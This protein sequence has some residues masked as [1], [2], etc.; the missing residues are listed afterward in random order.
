MN[1]SPVESIAQAGGFAI[2]AGCRPVRARNL[3]VLM[4]VVLCPA[5]AETQIP[6]INFTA[7]SVIYKDT[8]LND[9]A[10]HYAAGGSIRFEASEIVLP[11]SD[12]AISGI[13]LDG[14]LHELSPGDRSLLLQ[15]SVRA[16]VYSAELE[17]SG[18]ATD[19]EVS[20]AIED[21]PLVSLSDIHGIPEQAG[22]LSGGALNAGLLYK[23]RQGHEPAITYRLQVEDLAFDSPQGRFAGEG[24]SLRA[25][26]SI[27]IKKSLKLDVSGTV[28]QGE[29]LIDNFYR[30][31]SDAA[32]DFA[33][34][35]GWLDDSLQL[36]TILLTDNSALVFEGRAEIPGGDNADAWVLEV[37]RL[38]LEFPAAYERYIEPA[39]T[40]WTLDGLGV[41]GSVNW[42]G[43]WDGG[44]FRSGDL[45]VSDLTIVDILRNRFAITGL[46]TRLRPGDH[47]FDSKLEWRGLLF[48]RINLG[49]GEV[50]LD[51]EPGVIALVQPLVLDVLGGQLNLQELKVVLPGS[52][53]DLAGEPDISLRASLDDLDVELLTAA[54]E[55]PSF[56][57]KLSGEVP[58]VRL[59]DGVLEV[60]GEILVSVF[61]GEVSMREL[62][63]ERPFGVLPSLA[64]N[65]EVSNLDLELLT[66]T[67]S[68]GQISGR[69]DGYV[70]NLRM[71]DWRPVAFDAWL[72]TPQS[73]DEKNNIS[74]QAV[75][76]LTTIG[77]G[78]ATT[79]LTS[80][81]LRMFNSFS[82]RRLGL[83]CRLQNDACEV[84]GIGEDEVSVLL[85]EGAGI[86]KITIRAFN[87][88]VDWQQMVANLLAISAEDPIRT[89]N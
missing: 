37:N 67:F 11:D 78:R 21:L 88:R 41:T 1:D 14:V 47:S 85:M 52:S 46:D 62:R 2:R 66:S 72:G 77:G 89:G 8:Q 74:R 64:A 12:R 32:L 69:L 36:E 6:Q 51:S 13:G 33:F 44:E 63:V 24:L 49:A 59:Q 60:D 5:V 28:L 4:A 54:M 48:G 16:D 79:A 39:A 81:L 15:G 76:H 75:N 87:R 3:A 86:P 30:D 22:W 65:I 9:V 73:Q 53:V 20:L 84:R 83:G 70:R 17:A 25:G 31:F 58:G 42:S 7:E 23:Q 55:W 45:E 40:A 19:F 38:N 18:N 43:Q 57:G 26:G 68:F 80:P 27:S 10:L 82:Y 34:E 29:L 50:A 56:T 71:L 35:P 61:D